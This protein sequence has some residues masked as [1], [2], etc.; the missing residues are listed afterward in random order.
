MLNCRLFRSIQIYVVY[1]TSLSPF[2]FFFGV[3]QSILPYCTR[4]CN[5]VPLIVFYPYMHVSANNNYCGIDFFVFGFSAICRPLRTNAIKEKKIYLQKNFY[6]DRRNHTQFHI[7]QINA[8]STHLDLMWWLIYIYIV[9]EYA[10]EGPRKFL[11]IVVYWMSVLLTEY[12]LIMHHVKFDFET[13]WD[14]HFIDSTGFV[15][16]FVHAI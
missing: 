14:F 16:R 9:Y 4:F 8:I 6:L 11:S 10:A 15:M 12:F 2:F 7:D 3:Y 1:I 5:V 13:V